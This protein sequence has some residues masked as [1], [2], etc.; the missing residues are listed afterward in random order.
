MFTYLE[1]AR[2]YAED[3]ALKGCPIEFVH[4]DARNFC[5]T[6]NFDIALNLYTSFGYCEKPEDDE[7]II[8]NIS[9]SLVTGGVFC[10]KF[11]ERKQR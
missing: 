4:A 3:P 10:L 1:L 7:Q 8:R 6:E 9:A 5:R 11:W 2:E